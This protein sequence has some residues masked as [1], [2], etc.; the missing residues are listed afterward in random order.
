MHAFSTT[1]MIMK[2]KKTD[3]NKT[4]EYSF[5]LT[6]VFDSLMQSVDSNEKYE[7]EAIIS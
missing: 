1:A 3:S 4:D 6:F 5:R 7:N 2:T